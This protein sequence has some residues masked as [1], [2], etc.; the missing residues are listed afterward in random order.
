M[1]EPLPDINDTLIAA[2]A[3]RLLVLER[4]IER[5]ACYTWHAE[6]CAVNEGY[7]CTCGLEKV[8]I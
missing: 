7:P 8:E 5:L 1:P 3:T 2:L 6:G 4:Q